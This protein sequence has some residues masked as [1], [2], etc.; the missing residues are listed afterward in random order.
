MQ[1]AIDLET[2]K[3]SANVESSGTYQMAMSGMPTFNL[4][5]NTNN[6]TQLVVN[7]KVVKKDVVYAISGFCTLYVFLALIGTLLISTCN[8]NLTSSLSTALS[9]LGNIGPGFDAIGPSYNV[10]F[11]P[12]HIKWFLSFLMMVGRLELYSVLVLFMPIFWKR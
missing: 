7:G 10:A 9:M 11:F 5:D 4:V 8:L 1:N 12:A 6:T 2:S 3:L